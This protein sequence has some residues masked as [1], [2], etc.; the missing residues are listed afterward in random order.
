MTRSMLLAC[1]ILLCLLGYPLSLAF[2]GPGVSPN[3]VASP[4]LSADFPGEKLEVQAKQ[5]LDNLVNDYRQKNLRKFM[6]NVSPDFRGE[7][8]MLAMAIR[9]D[10]QFI[11][12]T[13]LRYI[14]LD[15]SVADNGLVE[16]TIAY[17]RRVLS[18][19]DGQF[20][21]DSGLTQL[22]FAVENGQAKLL[23]MKYPLIFGLSDAGQLAAGGITGSGENTQVITVDR[24]GKI[25]ILPFQQAVQK[26][27]D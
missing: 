13:E 4:T 27:R 18:S 17:S 8:A 1:L 19:R 7:Y 14:V 11:D 15:T 25:K 9:R 16:F 12:D 26:L 6:A 23:G 24:Q 21:K 20:Y 5:V 22:L 2:A 10:F 3:A